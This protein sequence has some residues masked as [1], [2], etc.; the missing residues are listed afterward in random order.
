ME[1]IVARAMQGYVGSKVQD[2]QKTF[3]ENY[4]EYFT[5]SENGMAKYVSVLIFF[6][7]SK[8]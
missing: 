1:F 4:I 6:Y 7:I 2:I 5:H 3:S 8:F